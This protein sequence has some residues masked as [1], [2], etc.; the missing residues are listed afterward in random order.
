MCKL[1]PRTV[2]VLP[3]PVLSRTFLIPSRLF[4]FSSFFWRPFSFSLW[5]SSEERSAVRLSI[6]HTSQTS[7]LTN[8][9]LQQAV[10]DITGVSVLLFL[11]S[12][13]FTIEKKNDEI[14]CSCPPRGDDRFRLRWSRGFRPEAV[15]GPVVV[16]C[17]S[18]DDGS[19]LQRQEEELPSG[20]SDEQG[21][22]SSWG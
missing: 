20:Q 18:P 12:D 4:T 16:D 3:Q 13:P 8:K 7:Y 17:T 21:N 14:C 6:D 9:P 19:V 5:L 11:E 1:R 2:D 22:C 10:L 15:R